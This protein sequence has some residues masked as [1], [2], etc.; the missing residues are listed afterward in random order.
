MDNWRDHHHHYQEVTR[1]KLNNNNICKKP[2]LGGSSNWQQG[3]P[4]WE[5]KF[6]ASV[7]SI[8]WK[9]LVELKK[10][11]HL[12]DNVINWNDSAGK[13]AFENAKDKFYADMYNLPH[14]TWLPDPDIYIDN[15]NWDSEV[16]PNLLLDLESNSV[17]P[18]SSSKDEQ[19]IIFGS[20]F[21]PSYQSFSTYGW[22]DSD[23]DQ[24][25]DIDPN[26]SP[27]YNGNHWE[28]EGNRK[29]VVHNNNNGSN[30]WG[31]IENDE[32]AERD[33]GWGDSRNDYW[34][35]NM[36]DNNNYFYADV[37]NE[38]KV[39]SGRYA[40]KYKTSRSRKDDNQG[41]RSRRNNGNGTKSSNY[42]APVN[43]SSH[44]GVVA[45]RW[46]VKK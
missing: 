10:F 13:E 29:D 8:P 35:W 19:V 36:Y 6:C 41:S 2:P 18:D 16:D 34:G 31:S 7:G 27:E 15:I 3:V 39:G 11:I 37:R 22:G 12:Y 32:T 30:W 9:K 23:D 40:S 20:T 4:S 45:H 14:N 5:K 21:P 26:T 17:V 25:K 43:P 42:C 28:V 24:K 46:S 1:T 33:Q 44:G 38:P